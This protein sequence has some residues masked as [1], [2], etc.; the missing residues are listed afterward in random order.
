MRD[1]QHAR[2]TLSDD[3]TLRGGREM[4]KGTDVFLSPK[5]GRRIYAE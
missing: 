1:Q 2:L 3:D 4:P 5:T